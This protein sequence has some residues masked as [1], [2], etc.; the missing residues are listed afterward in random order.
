MKRTLPETV[1]EYL[2]FL[3]ER[4]GNPDALKCFTSP[5]WNNCLP[6]LHDAGIAL[7]FL[8]RLKSTGNSGIV[9][10]CIVDNLE[11]CFDANRRR[12]SYLA[13]RFRMINQQFEETGVRYAVVKGFSLVPQFCPEME[14]R[15]MSDL[16]YL[17]DPESLPTAQ[18]VIER[19]GY[20]FRSSTSSH[21][22]FINRQIAKRPEPH[23]QYDAGTPHAVELHLSL[24]EAKTYGLSLAEPKF[25][26]C[27]VEIQTWQDCLFPAL[28]G[29]D[30]FLL[31]CI[32][33]FGH[34]LTYWM[35]MSWLYE[36]SYFLNRQATDEMFWVRFKDRAEHDPVVREVVA[37][38][39]ALATQFFSA[40]VPPLIADW[41]R[42]VR[43][44]VRVWIDHYARTWIFGN[45]HHGCD[46]VFFPTAKLVLFL[47]QQYSSDK[48]AIFSKRLIPLR[49][50]SQL[51]SKRDSISG[52]ILGSG[53][54]SR[55]HLLRKTL[56]HVGSGVR[57]VWE[58]P[59]WR[60]LNR[61]ILKQV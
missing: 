47:H 2:G 21:F 4:P 50:F 15:L 30:V 29:E 40:P 11:H 37:V 5:E 52:T 49:G 8:Q 19:A 16:D 18:K 58:V 41:I 57:Y 13:D 31:Q 10:K 22:A 46:F 12:T 55:R 3:R 38:V 17:V 51:F 45:N 48:D 23:E 32:H 6:W 28:A 9:P 60:R 26:P 44:A 24:W 1:V 54:R 53:L 33:A 36:I 59:R 42:K 34:I 43:P 25:L 56:F 27:E 35:R 20:L 61:I 14:L 7:Y 39:V